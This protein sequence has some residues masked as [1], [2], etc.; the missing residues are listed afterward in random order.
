LWRQG[1]RLEIWTRTKSKPEN[2]GVAKRLL[3]LLV[4]DVTFFAL[5]LLRFREFVFIFKWGWHFLPLLRHPFA[6]PLSSIC[7]SIA[8][9]PFVFLPFCRISFVVFAIPFHR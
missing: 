9:H 7:H 8:T 5:Y 6:T 1:D 4:G 3:Q 2:L